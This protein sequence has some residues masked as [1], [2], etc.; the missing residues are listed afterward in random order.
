[1]PQFFKSRIPKPELPHLDLHRSDC[2]RI[3]E[4]SVISLGAIALVG[5]AVMGIV[6][7]LTINMHQPK[8]VEKIAKHLLKYQFPDRSQG[9]IGLSIGAESFAV[10]TDRADN[11]SLRLFVQASPVA[12][13]ERTSKIVREYA[14]D[15][16]WRGTWEAVSD[17][18][19]SFRYCNEVVDL[20]IN[21]GLWS[22][23]ENT[24][25]INA[26]EYTFDTTVDNYDQ[27][28]RILATGR[29]AETRA[30]TLLN[31]LQCRQKFKK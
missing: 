17:E 30:R 27:T 2:V 13:E 28:I 31:S 20:E 24:P 8:R 4:V 12:M 15:A 7:K 1:M 14:L 21:R 16:V 23:D 5:A 25:A 18:S 9:Q 10:V 22:I 6:N 19:Q 26:I 29:D 3:V 11:P